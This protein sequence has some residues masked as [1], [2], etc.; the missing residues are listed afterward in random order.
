MLAPRY[1]F[2]NLH[3]PRVKDKAHTATS[4]AS[5]VSAQ[6]QTMPDQARSSS[7]C[8]ACVSHSKMK[9]ANIDALEASILWNGHAAPF[10]RSSCTTVCSPMLQD[11]TSLQIT[12]INYL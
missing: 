9:R 10:L 1:S 5:I 2:G 7:Y 8:Y 4:L 12:R 6:H 11:T 3:A